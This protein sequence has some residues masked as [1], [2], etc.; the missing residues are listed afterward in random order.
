MAY[1]HTTRSTFRSELALRLH[2]SSLVY[3]GTT[4][5]NDIIDET[6]LTWGAVSEYWKDQQSFNTVASTVFYDL[7]SNISTL[8]PAKSDTDLTRTI[9][10]H[11]LEPNPGTSWTG[12]E[13][14]TLAQVTAALQRRRN[15]FLLETGQIVVRTTQ[16]VAS[17]P[18]NGRVALTG[19]TTLAV[20]RVGWTNAVGDVHV[21]YR[22][23]EFGVS[24][25]DSTWT[26]AGSEEPETW[27][28]YSSPTDTLQLM[29]VHNAAG[30]LDL[31]LIQAGA[32]LDPSA[33]VGLGVMENWVWVIKW[34]AMADLLGK[35]GPGRD[36]IRAQYCEQRYREGVELAKISGVV[37]SARIGTTLVNPTPLTAADRDDPYWQGKSAGTPTDL[38]IASS[39]LV[40]L[41]KV[42]DGVYAVTLDVVRNA[43][44]PTTDGAY[45]DVA[46]DHLD[47]LLDYAEHLAAFKMGGVEWKATQRG[48]E[49]FMLQAA[50]HGRRDRAEAI[51]L[52]NG[53]RD[54][55]QRESNYVP[56]EQSE[57]APGQSAERY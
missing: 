6:L 29:P 17:F 1:T 53:R 35:D 22:S 41:R 28:V 49:N 16:A 21:L 55:S 36:P 23:D 32:T 30:T 18:S 50:R 12:T 31:L 9:Q 7:R 2:D 15:Q 8:V 56:R 46:P 44:Y 51:L 45:I 26:T 11:L 38:L 52:A 37:L 13:M 43:P 39:N 27:S 47:L 42:P 4:E 19:D 48:M 3:W 14:W 20:R 10:A 24:G 40:A 33:G 34:G 5:L 25:W 57:G 54:L